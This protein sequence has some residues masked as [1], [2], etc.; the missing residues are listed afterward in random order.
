MQ[1]L[2]ISIVQIDQIWEDKQANFAAYDA[3]LNTV[4]HTDLILLPEMFQT[5]FTMNTEL[6]EP[7]ETSASVDWL[8]KVAHK[9]DAAIFT[10]LSILDGDQCYNRGVFMLPSG[11]FHIYDKRKS[12]AM[13]GEHEFYTAG[14]ERTIVSY[15]GWKFQ[16]QICYDLRFP[17]ISRNTLDAS[18][19]PSFDVLLYVA[20][21]PV[22]RSHHWNTL[23][24]ARAIENQCF[25]AASNRVGKDGN[26]FEYL[27]GSKIV[28]ALGSEQLLPDSTECAQSFVIKKNE[29]DLIRE[30]LPFLSDQTL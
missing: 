18:G 25:V 21:W 1:D 7:F 5:G 3:Q 15:K 4:E 10:S 17:E 30:K 19:Q 13:A 22:K 8:K 27:G 23:L 24:T 28:D 2:T 14:T 29:L 12:F 20:N 16:L 9:K 6:A 26:G 11:E